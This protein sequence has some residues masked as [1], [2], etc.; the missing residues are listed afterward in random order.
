[1]ENIKINNIDLIPELNKI[2]DDLLKLYEILGTFK[3]TGSVALK[4]Y[5]SKY[6]N[7]LDDT[8]KKKCINITPN[9]YDIIQFENTEFLID[10]NIFNTLNT[11][12]D[13]LD[14]KDNIINEDI[15]IKHSSAMREGLKLILNQKPH[16]KIDY[17]AGK[18]KTKG[19]TTPE[20]NNIY[21][22]KLE[23]DKKIYLVDLPIL[24]IKYNTVGKN[25]D[26]NK[27][28][29]INKLITILDIKK[30]EEPRQGSRKYSSL[31][32]PT[33]PLRF[34]GNNDGSK[35]SKSSKLFGGLNNKYK[36]KKYK[37]KKHNTKKYKTK[38]NKTKKYNTK[39]NKTKKNK[40]KK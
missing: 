36:T 32:K 34:N 14:D 31:R 11:N 28:N 18:A 40:T 22:Y 5:C 1:M 16:L 12:F 27:I 6:L 21:T 37:T 29:I 10:E 38:N 25:V 3:L 35:P 17:I 15:T 8:D 9:D 7:D 30:I 39:K 20:Y 4:I 26:T 13:L 23:K 2:N 19:L 24:L 33:F